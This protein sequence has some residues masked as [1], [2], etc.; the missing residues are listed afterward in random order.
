MYELKGRDPNAP[1]GVMFFMLET[2][3]RTLDVLGERT[4]QALRSLL[5]GPVTL[6]IRNPVGL[7][8]LAAGPRG[9]G[10]RVPALDDVL[11]PLA[12]VNRP[13]LQTSANLSGRS[14]AIQLADIP[15]SIRL[16]ADYMLDAGRLA[17]GPSTVVDLGDYE[18][19][20]RWELIREGAVP[21]ERIAEVLDSLR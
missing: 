7:F 14:E 16:G 9:L 3:L 10:I 18:S 17:G 1:S 8:P 19:S 21:R 11:A 2:A 6:V 5:P 15:G 13:V 12:A 4:E 20:G